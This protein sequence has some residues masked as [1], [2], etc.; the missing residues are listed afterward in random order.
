M[1]LTRSEGLEREGSTLLGGLEG[2][3]LAR[4]ALE[5]EEEVSPPRDGEACQ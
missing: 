1:G 4:E 2:E 5:E 3:T